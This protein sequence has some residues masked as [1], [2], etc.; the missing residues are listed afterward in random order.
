MTVKQ[1]L[2]L[3]QGV[4]DYAVGGNTQAKLSAP[5]ASTFVRGMVMEEAADYA[6]T[7]EQ[8]AFPQIS[9]MG[10]TFP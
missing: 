6:T 5:M 7:E 2:P 10:G 9:L 3:P 8:M 1:P 4:S